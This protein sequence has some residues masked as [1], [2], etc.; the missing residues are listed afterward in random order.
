MGNTCCNY[1]TGKDGKDPHALEDGT[2]GKPIKMDPK[3]S[4]ELLREVKKNEKKVVKI[5]AVWRGH[6]TRKRL[7]NDDHINQK[8]RA[9]GR[10]SNRPANN[11]GAVAR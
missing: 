2:S 3:V 7:K 11:G 8:P 10:R 4:E 1:Q 5:Q 9:S 6:S